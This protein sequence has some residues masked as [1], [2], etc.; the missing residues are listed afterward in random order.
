MRNYIEETPQPVQPIKLQLSLTQPTLLEVLSIDETAV[1]LNRAGKLTTDQVNFVRGQ[2]K[3]DDDG[4]WLLSTVFI[5]T[6]LLLSLIFLM[7]GLNM[8]YLLLGGVVFLGSFALYVTRKR[9]GR[10]RDLDTRVSKVKGELRIH[11]L[12]RLGQWAMVIGHKLFPISEALARK[13]DGYD[14]P[15]VAAYYT[16]GTN[17]LLSMEVIGYEKRKN[18]VLAD[19]EDEDEIEQP[20]ESWEKPKNRLALDETPEAEEAVET[21][22]QSGQQEQSPNSKRRF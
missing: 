15:T 11:S 19:D 3:Q 4:T 22:P 18:D 14:M 13:F 8:A 20:L 12:E 16:E 2:M 21:E 1:R 9:L 17:T 6:A 5:G 10:T 7:Q